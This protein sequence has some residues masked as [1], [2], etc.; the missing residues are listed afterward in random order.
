ME[1]LRQNF[2][3]YEE[4]GQLSESG[5]HDKTV[6]AVLSGE[7]EVVRAASGNRPARR[8]RLTKGQGAV[9]DA[10]G[11]TIARLKKVDVKL[12]QAM[13]ERLAKRDAA[14]AWWSDS[15]ARISVFDG[16][17]PTLTQVPPIVPVP[18]RATWAPSSAPWMAAENPAEP[19]PTTAKS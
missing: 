12:V 7:V 17:Q 1:M 9:V 2:N 4:L 14:R 8:I 6:M 10:K 5:S 15:A 3:P 16:T 11:E 18:M 13:R 19:A